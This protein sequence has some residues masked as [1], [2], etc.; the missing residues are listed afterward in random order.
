M[1]SRYIHGGITLILL[2]FMC[3]TAIALWRGVIPIEWL[4]SLG[5]KGIFVISL[6]NGIA[7][8]A[9]PSQVATFFVASKLNPLA[10]GVTA[11]AGGAIGEL[12]GYAFGYSFRAAQSEEGE[13]K[14]ERIANWR[15]LRITRERSFVPLF[16]LASVPNPF[17]DP[18]SVIAGSL[19]IGFARYFIPV[20]LGKITRHVLIGLAGYYTLSGDAVR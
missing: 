9:G 5:Y 7:P 19:R 8:V 1:K 15:F 4:A 20:L 3:A 10:V 18:A 2:T 17:F 14:I 11:G 13:R 6:I 16:V 12:A